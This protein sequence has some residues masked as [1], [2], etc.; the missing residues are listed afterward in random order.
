MKKY[1]K[2]LVT[3]RDAFTHTGWEDADI[4]AE[5]ASAVYCESVGYLLHQNKTDIVLAQ[6][7]GG[8]QVNGRITIP[9]D[10]ICG[11]IVTLKT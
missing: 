10:W 5:D 2:V 1:R 3:W 9:R 11:K 6:T 7:I 4:S 8:D